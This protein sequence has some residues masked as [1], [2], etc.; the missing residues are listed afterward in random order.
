M[1]NWTEKRKLEI[2]SCINERLISIKAAATL[3][4]V[5]EEEIEKWI[6]TKVE[7]DQNQG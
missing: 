5:T 2:A 6:K 4:G 1:T 7:R 3:Y